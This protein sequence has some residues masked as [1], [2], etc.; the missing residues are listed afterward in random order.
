MI[1]ADVFAVFGTLLALGIALPGLLLT[2]RLLLPKMVNRAQARLGQ[3][4]WKCF[5]AGSLVLVAYLVPVIILISLPWGVFK[6]IGSGA[7]FVLLTLTSVGA[8]GLAGLM[9]ERLQSLGL[10]SSVPG[11]TL[12]GA[13]A[14]ELAAIFPVVGWFIFIPLTFIVSL[15]ATV[16]ALVGWM[17]RSVPRAPAAQSIQEAPAST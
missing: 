6:A 15:G 9:G 4:P 17:P 12:R 8:A 1:M 2:W 10:S 16:F 14:M 3:T 11:A 7:I 13:V 5:F